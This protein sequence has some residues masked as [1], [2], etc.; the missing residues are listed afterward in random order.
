M[1][2]GVPIEKLRPKWKDASPA[3]FAAVLKERTT[4][5]LHFVAIGDER[6]ENTIFSAGLYDRSKEKTAFLHVHQ[7]AKPAEQAADGASGEERAPWDKPAEA[8]KVEASGSKFVPQSKFNQEDLWAAYAV[9]RKTGGGTLIVTDQFGNEY[10]RWAAAPRYKDLERLIDSVPTLVAEK[11]KK[12][13][14][15]FT[16]AKAQ[17]EKGAIEKSIKH[18]LTLFKSGYVGQSPMKEAEELYESILSV[19]REKIEL[20]LLHSD[21]KGLPE[22][23]KTYKG[24]DL[25]HEID[26]AEKEIAEFKAAQASGKGVPIGGV[27][28]K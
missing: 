13:Q 28:K 25:D 4:V 6:P 2:G 11:A 17:H 19:G 20:A 21:A 18:L 3:E 15:E 12:L 9:D 22:L 5:V 24:T 10:K 7:E 14:G 27:A 23:R 16:K 8:P 1:G 26:A